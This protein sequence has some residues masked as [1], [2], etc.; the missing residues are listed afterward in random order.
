[1]S[2]DDIST[3]LWRRFTGE[4]S[5]SVEELKQRIV[6]IA[7]EHRSSEWS[8]ADALEKTAL[9]VFGAVDQVVSLPE[10]LRQPVW[11]FIVNILV[12]ETYIWFPVEMPEF[13]ISSQDRVDITNH[14]RAQELFLSNHEELSGLLIVSVA[15]LL[16]SVLENISVPDS[17]PFS[18]PFVN[19]IPNPAIFIEGTIH[20]FLEERFVHAGL[21]NKLRDQLTANLPGSK[22][23]TWPTSVKSSPVE[24]VD[25]FFHDTALHDLFLTPCPFELPDEQ[26]FSGMWVI[27]S[28]GRGKTTTSER[29]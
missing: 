3:P 20:A 25:T 19:C 29:N 21:F 11:T 5:R 22:E 12:Q 2:R 9:R 24:L 16:A 23:I 17:T 14:L 26:R 28:H 13:P 8:R 7:T 1:M 27:A 4:A 10:P 15:Q 18:I 6:H